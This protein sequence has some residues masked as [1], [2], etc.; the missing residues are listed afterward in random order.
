M[1]AGKGIARVMGQLGKSSYGI[2]LGHM[3]VLKASQAVL[4]SIFNSSPATDIIPLFLIAMTV[5]CLPVLI[6][7]N[8]ISTLLGYY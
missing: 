2:F 6:K 8:S 1:N 3:A 5:C 7:K 4:H